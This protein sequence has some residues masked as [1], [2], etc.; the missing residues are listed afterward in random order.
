MSDNETYSKTSSHNTRLEGYMVAEF[1]NIL[2]YWLCY[3]VQV[4]QNFRQKLSLWNVGLL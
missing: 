2:G 3:L 1:S 4:N